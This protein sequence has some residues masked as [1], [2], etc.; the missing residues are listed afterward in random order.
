MKKKF[1]IPLLAALPVLLAG[2]SGEPNISQYQRTGFNSYQECMAAYRTQMQAGLQ[3]PCT[4]NRTYVGS[5]FRYYGPYLHND[6]SNTRYLGYDADGN[7]ARQGLRYD[8][9]KGTFGSY[10][11]STSRG[12]LTSGSRG[13]GGG[14]GG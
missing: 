2:C 10:K 3:N 5:G 9:A 7:P 11:A 4:A 6:G 12:G 14:F 8:N 1:H 13:R